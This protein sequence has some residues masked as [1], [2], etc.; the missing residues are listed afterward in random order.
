MSVAPLRYPLVALEGVAVLQGL[1]DMAQLLEMLP[2]ESRCGR[3][4][5]DAGRGRA[6]RGAQGAVRRKSC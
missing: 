1:G 3:A 5:L 6:W 2:R 4:G